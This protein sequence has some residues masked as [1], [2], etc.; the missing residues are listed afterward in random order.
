[1][2]GGVLFRDYPES[3]SREKKELVRKNNFLYL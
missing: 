3:L 2:D 1:M